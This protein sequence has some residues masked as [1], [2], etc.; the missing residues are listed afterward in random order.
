MAIKKT[1]K[2]T[3]RKITPRLVAQL[4]AQEIISGNS[5]A[6]A[7]VLEGEYYGT[8]SAIRARAF[9]IAA[10]RKEESTAEY[11]E[12][13]LQQ[14]AEGAIVRLGELVNSG[15]EQVAGRAVQYTLDHIRG[16]AVT[17]NIS[18]TAKTNIQSV[19]D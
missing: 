9:K 16:K 15:D 11:I 8:D 4:D 19:L 6:A 14:I 18:V 2:R 10:K 1:H 13:G 7:R 3:Y 12:N 17:R 5:T